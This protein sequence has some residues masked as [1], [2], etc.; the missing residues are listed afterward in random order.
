MLHGAE[1]RQES[2]MMHE[3]S[4]VCM[5]VCTQTAWASHVCVRHWLSV[6]LAARLLVLRWVHV[7]VKMRGT[8]AHALMH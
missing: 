4:G 5:A 3:V 2:L 8:P 6:S 7:L 1:K